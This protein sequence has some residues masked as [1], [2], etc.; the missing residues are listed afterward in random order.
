[1]PLVAQLA[2]LLTKGAQKLMS[3]E[4]GAI[5]KH[6]PTLRVL[7][8]EEEA[9]SFATIPQSSYGLL[10]EEPAPITPVETPVDQLPIAEMDV[11][12][13][14]REEMD[15][16]VPSQPQRSALRQQVEDLGLSK[17]EADEVL[18]P[19]PIDINQMPEV[20][21][22]P[23]RKAQEQGYTVPLFHF[24]RAGE[25]IQFDPKGEGTGYLNPLLLKESEGKDIGIHL[26]TLSA[27]SKQNEMLGKPEA[28]VMG[29]TLRKQKE[30]QLGQAMLPLV[31]KLD[32]V[33]IVPDMG[34]FKLPSKW[35]EELSNIDVER[36]PKK[37]IRHILRKDN[38]E[39]DF[40]KN[41][42]IIKNTLD[43][44]I[45]TVDDLKK[46]V[47]EN[48]DF[49]FWPEDGKFVYLKNEVKLSKLDNFIAKVS[50][51]EG[52]KFDPLKGMSPTLWKQ[53]M[54]AA[55]TF[56]MKNIFRNTK[57]LDPE[58]NMFIPEKIHPSLI[59]GW[60]KA[61]WKILED[62]GY[63][64]FAYPNFVEDYG[65]FS[66]MFLDPKKVKSI[67]AKEFDPESFSF[68]KKAGGIV[69]MRNGGTVGAAVVAA[70]LMASGGQAS[71]MENGGEIDSAYYKDESQQ[72]SLSDFETPK[73]IAEM[74]RKIEQNREMA[75]GLGFKN[76][77][78]YHKADYEKR[79]GKARDVNAAYWKKYGPMGNFQSKQM[80]GGGTGTEFILPPGYNLSDETV[81]EQNKLIKNAYAL[82][83]QKIKDENKAAGFTPLT[84]K[85][86]DTLAA[87]EE[88]EYEK[89][90]ERTGYV[91]LA[92]LE[93]DWEKQ[94]AQIAQ[95]SFVPFAKGGVVDMRNGGVVGMQDGGKLMAT[96]PIPEEKPLPNTNQMKHITGLSLDIFNRNYNR[97]IKEGYVTAQQRQQALENFDHFTNEVL[98]IE[99]DGNWNAKNKYGF[100][101][102]YQFGDND[103]DMTLNRLQRHYKDVNDIPAWVKNARKHKDASRLTPEQ[104]TALFVT[105]MFERSLR[106]D[107][108]NILKGEGDKLLVGAMEGDKGDMI[109]S[110]YKLHYASSPD[111]ATR[112][113]ANVMFR[114]GKDWEDRIFSFAKGVKELI[115]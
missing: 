50:R 75:Q 59:D 8:P 95:D 44:S 105:N 94:D 22:A 88:E 13:P 107:K 6:E 57:Q 78:E 71:L 70:S 26:G 86:F 60:F 109:D 18:I 85:Y 21:K 72:T 36:N 89:T 66:Y 69:D 97:L 27:M 87:K 80:Q 28:K 14:V 5:M 98:K 7:T 49:I 40:N 61:L 93:R 63:D 65:A 81:G 56:H 48:G 46:Y 84:Q 20:W 34:R 103:V 1:M 19:D 62:N 68:G 91:N 51:M 99:S 11:V 76:F 58:S 110:Y 112:F 96:P 10:P 47:K 100:K 106:D 82:R 92:Q 2:K 53:L 55:H 43:P 77:S 37:T 33:A 108:G 41:K 101:G 15:E 23:Y 24:T 35:L 4:P 73:Q 39:K 64:A 32:N 83:N 29:V 16:L 42:D 31:T 3:P 90:G 67:F 52:A 12:P 115:N 113:R 104:Q 45:E 38:L 79:L 9:E 102:G 25:K 30:E 114:F 111:L 54:E 74:Q 17:E